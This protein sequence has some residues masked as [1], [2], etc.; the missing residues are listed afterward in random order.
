MK[1]VT[2]K[3][4]GPILNLI[5]ADPL[6]ALDTE[7]TG[8]DDYGRDRLFSIAISTADEDYYFNFNDKPDHLGQTPKTVLS[9]TRIPS[10]LSGYKGRVFF[11]NQPFDEKMLEH[12]GLS[13]SGINCYDTVTL[14]RLQYNDRLNCT[15]D[16]LAKEVGA[17]KI[18]EVKKYIMVNKLYTTYK[19]PAKKGFQKYLHFDLVPM[20]LTA[21]YACMDT[22]ITRKLGVKYLNSIIR[23]DEENQNKKKIRDIL[24]T[25]RQL[26]PILKKSKDRGIVVDLPYCREAKEYETS[27]YIQAAK[28]YREISGVDF[29]DS[30]KNHAKA[31]SNIG[32]KFPLTEKGNPSFTDEVLESMDTPLARCLQQYRSSYK[33]A[34]NYFATF[35][36]SARNGV[37]HPSL[38]P[39]KTRTG[40]FSASNPNLQNQKRTDV[41]AEG[42][43]TEKYPVRRAFIPRDGHFFMMKDFDQ[44]EYRMMLNKAG[45]MDVIAQVLEGLDVH[46]ATKNLMG[47]TR[48][49]A[50]TINFM[51]LYGGGIAVLARALYP[52]HLS[53][54]FLKE[55]QKSHY[56]W[57]EREWSN[58]K[59]ADHYNLELWEVQH[60]IEIL[61]KARL[62]KELYYSKLP[63]VK[64]FIK[65]RTKRAERSRRIYNEFGRC[66]TFRN[67]NLSYKAVNYEIQGETA[68]WIKRSMVSIDEYLKNKK[69]DILLQIHDELIFEVPFGEE[70]V[71]DPITKLMENVAPT[72]YLPYT[73]GTDFSTRS[74]ADKEPWENYNG[75]SN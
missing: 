10:L 50:K 11:H 55:I 65:N 23:Q 34:N 31:F 12:E 62:L 66:Y 60:G 16:F 49:E 5:H 42:N 45:Q 4:Y 15:L 63:K 44:F 29:I 41:D 39:N 3:E 43:I 38:N 46:T 14:A 68:D 22:N 26:V 52:T 25:E 33:K 69:T 48:Y 28:D 57:G 54:F 59:I 56:S 18:D 64:T 37:I 73:V 36:F 35:E 58:K 30:S 6:I 9:R 32:E 71:S 17:K 53:E 47:V 74:W 2:E 20:L 1:I 70:Y 40:R 67:P 21:E 72:L 27:R 24:Q 51:L 19:D 13:L 61:E 8:L 75:K 7:T